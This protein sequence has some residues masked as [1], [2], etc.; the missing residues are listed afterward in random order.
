MKRCGNDFIDILGMVLSMRKGIKS[1]FVWA[2]KPFVNVHE[3]FAVGTL[4]RS[5]K[6]LVNAARETMT[7]E[8]VET[9]ESF[10]DAIHRLGIDPATLQLKERLFFRMSIA[11][12]CMAILVLC[13]VLY[14][15]FSGVFFPG[16]FAFLIA[17]IILIYAY[18]FHFWYF[19]LKNRQLGCTF[20]D[21][22]N[23]KVVSEGKS[24]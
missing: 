23:A 24:Q 16:L 19:Q 6:A 15:F 14:L 18:R 2:F 20:R 17:M 5:S 11:M 22:L 7:P 13:Y 4:L 10:D 9:T 12:L 21:W 1:G 3:W 8:K